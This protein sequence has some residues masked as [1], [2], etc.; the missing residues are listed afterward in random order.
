LVGIGSGI[1][2]HVEDL[3]GGRDGG[4]LAAHQRRRHDVAGGRDGDAV[5][6][7]EAGQLA[8]QVSAMRARPGR[9]A[10]QARRQDVEAPQAARLRLG[11]VERLTLGA[12]ADAVGAAR[13]RIG[14]LHD[15]AA[16][17]RGPINAAMVAVA[18]ADLAEVAEPEAAAP[19]ELEVVRP[20]QP[21]PRAAV[22]QAAKP[23]GGDVHHLN[24]AA[25][26][27]RR[28]AH[29]AQQARRLVPGEAAIVAQD[30]RAVGAGRQA[31]RAA[32]HLGERGGGAVGRHAGDALRRD[33]DDRHAAIRQANGALGEAQALGQDGERFHRFPLS[34]RGVGP[35][36]ARGRLACMK[37]LITVPRPP[38]ILNGHQLSRPS[39]RIGR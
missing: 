6:P 37:T 1:L 20:L 14:R 16:I 31:I 38:H 15:A 12:D 27:I 23:A 4:D 34:G 26:I 30:Q 35:A 33:L 13:H 2:V 21:V 24:A 32:R 25:R 19:I 18:R 5:Q 22:I 39:A 3:P 9:L 29:R 28:L 8:E 11:D 36:R 10:Q 17:Q 7:A